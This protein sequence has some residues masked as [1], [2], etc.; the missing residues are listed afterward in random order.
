MNAKLESSAVRR[1]QGVV[2]FVSLII[3]VA[4]SLAG[5]AVMRTSGTG[6]LV[7]A[8]LAFKQSATASAD[9]GIEAARAWMLG[10]SGATLDADNAAIGYY[11]SWGTFDPFTFTWSGV[12]V[13]A[14]DA[15]GN[16][17]RFVVHRLCQTANTTINATGQQCIVRTTSSSGASSGGSA[18]G[19]GY[20]SF[21]LS[22]KISPYYRIT[23][24]AEGPKN[25][26]SYVQSIVE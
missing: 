3:L 4:M 2:L 22:S 12:P 10:Q 13:I 18:G 8:N 15:S 25:T 17:V 11:S 23:V 6:L 16:A 26:V 20:G 7:T 5:L 1:Q 24:R 19:V 21:N 14:A 9:R